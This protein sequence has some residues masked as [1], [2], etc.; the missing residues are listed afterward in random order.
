MVRKKLNDRERGLNY[1]PN[2]KLSPFLQIPIFGWTAILGVTVGYRL[3]RPDHFARTLLPLS[4]AIIA[5]IAVITGLVFRRY[6]LVASGLVVSLGSP[7][8]LV[9]YVWP[10]ILVL[11][12]VLVVDAIRGPMQRLRQRKR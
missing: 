6:F 8:V 11:A 12:L 7:T 1:V 10:L 9:W 5:M 3:V 4:F 2:H